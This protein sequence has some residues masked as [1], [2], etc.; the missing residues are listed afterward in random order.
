MILVEE[1]SS[2]Y[3]FL[4]SI[5]MFFHPPVIELAVVSNFVVKKIHAL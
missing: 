2:E 4:I 5:F 3:H 1:M